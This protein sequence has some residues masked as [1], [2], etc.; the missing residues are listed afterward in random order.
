[1]DI[2]QVVYFFVSPMGRSR[3]IGAT[4]KM[5]THISIMLQPIRNLLFHFHPFHF[6]AIWF[7]VTVFEIQPESSEN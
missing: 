4:S 1:M 6:L 7:P 2:L 5:S 3:K